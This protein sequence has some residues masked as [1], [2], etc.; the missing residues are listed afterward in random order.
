MSTDRNP[1]LDYYHALLDGGIE[2]DENAYVAHCSQFGTSYPPTSIVPF[3]C[4]RSIR[5]KIQLLGPKIFSS[6]EKVTQEFLET[7]NKN[8]T[9]E[10]PEHLKNLFHNH[11]GYQANHP[12]IRVDA[13]IDTQSNAIDILELNTADPSA[14][15]WNDWLLKGLL[16]CNTFTKF[17]KKNNLSW[18]LLI[19]EY[20]K[21]A[22][23]LYKEYTHTRKLNFQINP[24]IALLM[25]K[26]SSVYFDFLSLEFQLRAAGASVELIDPAQLPMDHAFDWLIR[27]TLDD[28]LCIDSKMKCPIAANDILEAKS[29]VLNPTAS[30]FGDQKSVLPLLDP[31]LPI[32]E[33][34]HFNS[35]KRM[36][37]EKLESFQKQKN[38]WVIKP[39]DG[40]GGHG[41]CVGIDTSKET[42]KQQLESGLTGEVD[43]IIQRYKDTPHSKFMV[44]HLVSDR[45]E[46]I[47]KNRYYNFSF[48]LFCGQYAGAFVRYSEQRVINTHQGGGLVP[49][50]YY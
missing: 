27:D 22:Q 36:T 6:L 44:K 34:H 33:T 37:H 15:S 4:P 13:F 8:V 39:S 9:V 25:P 19:P 23:S 38:E 42:W 12:V 26:V 32:L 2:E 35:K 30:V 40:Y 50:V 28:I 31:S 48:W 16:R 24:R 20:L 17:S 1:T 3:F 47:L 11:H 18:D 45:A 49:V 10:I 46:Y 43:I 41:V 14:F 29:F 21:L 5:D 7:N